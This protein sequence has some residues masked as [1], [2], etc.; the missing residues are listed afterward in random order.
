VQ[1]VP[2][3][4][5][6]WQSIWENQVELNISESG[7]LPMS[8]EELVEREEDRRRILGMPLGYPQTNGSEE[9][10]ANIATLYPGAKAENVL[11]TC[12]C[13]EANFLMTWSQV[14]PGDEIIFMLPNYMQV[15]GIAEA[16][17]ATVKPLWL[18]EEDGWAPDLDELRRLVTPKTRLIAICN[19]NN[20]TGAVLN[21]EAIEEICAVAGKA[22]TWILADE[23]YRGAEF[24]GKLSP[25]FWGRY[26]R[27]L[28]TA[29][30]SKAFSLPGLRTGW[31]VGAP[32]MIEKLWGYHDYTSIGPT[33][34]TDRLAA[35]A[36]APARREKILER[37]RRILRENYAIVSEWAGRHSDLFTHV[38]PRA[39][40]IAWFGCRKKWN[41][42]EFAEELRKRKGVLIVPGEQLGMKSYL[43][44]G[45]GGNSADLCGAL[46]RVDEM[47]GEMASA[48]SAKQAG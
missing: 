20:P 29:G 22:G 32:E 16:F 18:R 25:S 4:L 5:E 35:T 30:L 42:A 15:G 39:G 13:S 34:L 40:A 33:M 14:E 38:A 45:F 36:L 24:D 17:G 26:E 48:R 10:R 3:E 47:L 37:T 12:G 1:I 43:R 27:V 11:V 2:F 19:P 28:C 23:V 7:V 41:T 46:E 21:D 44:I 8:F 6:R 9:L 31:V